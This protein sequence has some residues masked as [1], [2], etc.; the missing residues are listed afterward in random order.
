[1][2]LNIKS[3]LIIFLVALLGAGIGTFGILEMRGFPLT[4]EQED[5]TLHIS[6]V[7]Y[8]N[9]EKSDLTKAIEKAYDTVVEVHA[10]SK[11]SSM[12]FGTSESESA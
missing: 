12:Y 1:M 8:P 10:K 3:L 2:K 11:N 9:V 6:E 7:S 5:H 4:D